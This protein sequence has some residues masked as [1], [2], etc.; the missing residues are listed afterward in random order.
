MIQPGEIIA[1]GSDHAGFQMKEYLK[2][3]LE[4][5]GY[6]TRDFGAFSE[7]SID[8]PDLI[9]P[10][11]SSINKGTLSLGIVI[12]GSGNGA[13]M[14]ANKYPHVRAAICWDHEIAKLARMH[15]DANIIALP[16]RFISNVHA[17]EYVKVF[18]NTVFEGGRHERRVT[19]ISDM[20]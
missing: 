17:A 3:N 2:K 14:V 13:A 8:Y 9:H 6:M 16:A 12:C 1:I 10:L 5:W 19:K 20:I 18:L 4:E 11:A 15:N 7:D